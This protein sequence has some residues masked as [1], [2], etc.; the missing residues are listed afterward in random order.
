VNEAIDPSIRDE[1]ESRLAAIEQRES[2]RYLFV[3]ESGSRAWGFPSP[4]SDYDVRFIYVRQ[5]NWYLSVEE[6]RDVI[7]T[8]ITD[9]IDLNGWDV[10]KA[11][12]LLMKSNATVSE[13]I[14]SPIRYRLD[15]PAVGK[16]VELANALFDPGATARHYA[17]LG[18]NAADRWLDAEGPVPVKKYFYS[19]RPAL[20]LRVLRQNPWKRPPMNLQELMAISD[21]PPPIVE[22][23]EE[24]VDAKRQT[25][26]LGNARRIPDLDSL[27]RSELGRAAELPSHKPNRR[28]LAWANELFLSLFD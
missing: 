20:A 26:E 24:L 12:G 27:I 11:L 25:R 21:L 10:R 28:G 15:D 23:V 3:V 8:P 22:A 16:L 17:S 13:W 6:R 5:R 2:I 4:D 18:K 9:D 7:E 19:L 14:A 1:I